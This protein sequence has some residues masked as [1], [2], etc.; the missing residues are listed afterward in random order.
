MLRQ[1]HGACVPRRSQGV[2]RLGGAWND[3][4]DGTQASPLKTIGGA[5][6]KLS[7][8]KRRIYFCVGTYAEDL[9]LNASHHNVSLFGGL[10]CDWK[11]TQ[12]RPEIGVSANP[13]TILNTPALAFANLVVHAANA[14]SGSSVAVFMS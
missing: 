3:A 12:E 9:A 4:N 6:G 7:A 13:V 1:S 10:D 11:P 8:T 2:L 5:L 14:Q